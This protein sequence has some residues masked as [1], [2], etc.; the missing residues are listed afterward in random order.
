LDVSVAFNGHPDGAKLQE[1]PI[2][3]SACR[4]L[5]QMRLEFGKLRTIGITNTRR[6]QELFKMVMPFHR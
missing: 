4:A 3:L 5:A 1:I 6:S 2:G